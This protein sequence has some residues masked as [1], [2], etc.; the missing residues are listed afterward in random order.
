MPKTEYRVGIIGCGSIGTRYA[1]AFQQLRDRVEVVA[2][3][4]ILE[5]K[6]NALSRTI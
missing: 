4:D 3:C 6:V 2:A 5:E 1:A